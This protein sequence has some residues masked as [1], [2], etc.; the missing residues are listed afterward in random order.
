MIYNIIWILVC[1]AVIALLIFILLKTHKMI[2]KGNLPFIISI[3]VSVI[4]IPTSLRG[5][6]YSADELINPRPFLK[7]DSKKVKITG[8]QSSGSLSGK[9]IPNA[10]VQFKDTD[11][12]QDT[13]NVTANNSGNF[14]IKKLNHYTDY[15]VTAI[16]NKKKSK[17]QKISVSDIP[18]SAY[19]KFHITNSNDMG[20]LTVNTGED[21]N[22]SITGTASPYATIKVTDPDM[23]Y[24][25]VKTIKSNSNGKWDTTLSGPGTADTDKKEKEYEFS[26][27]VKGRLANDGNSV[28]I[29]NPNHIKTKKNA[30]KPVNN[31]SSSNKSKSNDSNKKITSDDA[32]TFKNDN[33]ITENSIYHFTGYH[34]FKD[35]SGKN[36]I[37]IEFDYTNASDKEQ[38]PLDDL[39]FHVNAKQKTETHDKDLMP[40]Y[41]YNSDSKLEDEDRNN[42]MSGNILPH[43]TVQGVVSYSLVNNSKITLRFDDSAGNKIGTKSYIVN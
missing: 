31:D 35:M 5:I 29:E 22:V 36:S 15:K 24:S 14:K 42:N 25:V 4:L 26:A 39:T 9:T 37:A 33:Y 13:L 30:S 38:N 28:Y 1:I 12:I 32:W 40:A 7:L 27:K 17:P 8:T 16:K 18:D 3:I 10:K 43:K 2:S 20:S 19:T 21:N 41:P 11:G 34:F 23:D 6:F